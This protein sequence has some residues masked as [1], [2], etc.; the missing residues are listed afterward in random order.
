MIAQAKKYE[1][2][3]KAKDTKTHLLSGLVKCPVCGAGMYGNKSIKHRK[4]GSKYKDFYYYGC[5]HRTMTRGHKCGFKKQIQE[6]ILDASVV[7]IITKLV[8]NPR[9]ASLMQEKINM[10][11]DTT[12]IDQ[13]IKALEKQLKQS[14]A[15]KRKTL[16]EIEMLDP[17]DRHYNR[18]KADL[19]DRLYRMYDK[20]DD[21]E[22]SLIEARA[23][24]QSIETEKVTGDNIYKVLIY[25]EKLY[26][27]MNEE[28]QRK[29]ME[30]LI[31]EIQI[32]EERQPSGQWLKSITFRLPIIDSDMS[33]P[34]G[35]GL[36]SETHVE[37]VVQLSKGNISCQNV[38]VEFS[39]E[40]MD[41]SGF[42]QGATYEQIQEWIQEKYGFHVTHL[43][44]AK[45]KRKCG[46]I[47]RQNCNL[48]NR[49]VSRSPET[50]REKEEA[51]IDAFLYFKMM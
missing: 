40:D 50:P 25:F 23:K 6:E 33:M 26:A 28:E 38:R 13:E 32:Y 29:L 30:T 5:K 24:K 34:I 36:D 27:L 14:Y 20:I 15:M 39:L 22:Q 47:E 46:I 17:D 2:V 4:D 19:D 8:S 51:I 3:N 21:Q 42:Q 7:E 31:E 48:P 16:E 9:F 12:A 1:H 44:I 41:M 11:V 43:N 45:T 18:R 37:T 10:K 35:K 49:G